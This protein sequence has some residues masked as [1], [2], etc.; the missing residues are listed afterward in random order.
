M[1]PCL[2]PNVV[3][4]IFDY[5]ALNNRNGKSVEGAMEVA[6]EAALEEKLSAMGFSLTKASKR[7]PK[8]KMIVTISRRDMIDFYFLMT[9]QMKAGVSVIEALGTAAGECK[10]DKLKEIVIAVERKVRSGMMFFE[11]LDGFP[12]AFPPNV[13]NMARA[14]EMSCKLYETFGELREYEEWR[15]KMEADIRQAMTYPIIIVCV[16]STFILILFTFVIPKFMALLTELKVELPPLTQVV[17]NMSNFAVATWWMWI[18]G[19][20]SV[21]L[22][23]K[24]GRKRYEWLALFLDRLVLML[25]GFGK[26]YQMISVSR[27][28]HNL[29][30][31]TAAGLTVLDALHHCRELVGNKVVEF[32]VRDVKKEVT[33]GVDLS[34]AMAKHKVFPE[35]V[36][37]MISLGETTGFLEDALESASEFYNQVIPRQTKKIFTLMEPILMLFLIGV[38]GTLAL[39]IFL[40]IL[41][42]MIGVGPR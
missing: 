23:I 17:F 5:K 28:T 41:Q 38:V 33:A 24:Y 27:L 3:M 9:Y 6:D 16:V 2:V 31:L 13:A 7:K 22:G 40:P 25:P 11:A 8:K 35:M 14:G 26:L 21:V 19:V 37:R 1:S 4:P 15:E 36:I 34:E 42:M 39:S 18:L 29:S 32:A 20:V 30:S 12:E 10:N